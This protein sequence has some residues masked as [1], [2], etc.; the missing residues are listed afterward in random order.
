MAEPTVIAEIDGDHIT[1]QTQLHN[2]HLMH[3]VP[4]ARYDKDSGC[5][6]ALLSWSTCVI[7][8]GIY[9]D[10]LGVGPKLTQWSWQTYESRI[11]PALELRNAMSLSTDDPISQVID[12]IEARLEGQQVEAA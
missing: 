2:Q 9:G 3:Q 6:K 4:R 7:L 1:V 12:R 8:R 10:Q 5:W 11:G